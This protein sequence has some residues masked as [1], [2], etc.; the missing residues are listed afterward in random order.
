MISANDKLHQPLKLFSWALMAVAVG[1]FLNLCWFANT[2][3]LDPRY[4]F[5][6]ERITYNWVHQ[7]FTDPDLGWWD[8]IWNG[9]LE[10]GDHRYGR[11]FWNFSALV[12]WLPY[13]LGGEAGQLLA[14]RFGHALVLV[15]AYFILA[16]GTLTSWPYRALALVLF[17]CLPATVY[18]STMPKPEPL[19][20]LA[21]AIYIWQANQQQHR[22]GKYWFWLGFAYGVK[23]AALPWV[24]L[25]LLWSWL[26]SRTSSAEQSQVSVLK[27]LTTPITSVLIGLVVAEPLFLR[28]LFQPSLFL[29]YIRSTYRNTQHGDDYT[30]VTPF[31]WWTYV[32]KVYLQT[33]SWLLALLL[34]GLV[35]G[36]VLANAETRKQNPWWKSRS[37]YLFM[38]SMVAL[39]PI[40]LSVHRL[41]GYYL[42]VGLVLL[43]LACLAFDE[44]QSWLKKVT[45][46]RN[47]MASQ[48]AGLLVLLCIGLGAYASVPS[49]AAWQAA[50]TK[51]STPHEQHL[52]KA[53]NWTSDYA[54]K[55]A[56]AQQKP[57]KIALS[58]W[59][60]IPNDTILA[61]GTVVKYLVNWS[62]IGI[63]KEAD[64]IMSYPHR[65]G[66]EPLRSTI[67]GAVRTKMMNQQNAI[68]P[69]LMPNCTQPP[70][71]QGYDTGVD[72]LYLYIKVAGPN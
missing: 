14:T 42:N 31:T 62:N 33:P 5:M 68:I 26:N 48:L 21:M 53:M 35:T 36:L 3:V 1:Y 66:M 72:S 61:N 38:S 63:S 30:T 54:A 57:I 49:L 28:G 12:S 47:S 10:G 7:Q 4:L 37:V 43:I 20:L 9:W 70:C 41:W 32:T 52:R 55:V 44:E 40:V 22:P 11:I 18:H 60:P 23:I 69:H 56:Q 51:S 64:F 2:D 6:D 27:R 34:V 25:S 65:L 59:L 16:F 46:G 39:I 58:P 19:M 67:P 15:G 50:A 24:V 17:L 29:N 8:R 13:Q 71:Y 45:G